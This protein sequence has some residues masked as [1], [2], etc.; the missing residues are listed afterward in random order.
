MIVQDPELDPEDL[1]EESDEEMSECDEETNQISKSNADTSGLNDPS[2]VSGHEIGSDT[3]AADSKKND[4]NL[5]AKSG[6]MSENKDGK[7]KKE[8]SNPILK[9]F[10]FN[11]KN[12]LDSSNKQKDNSDQVLDIANKDQEEE[13]TPEERLNALH[14]RLERLEATYQQEIGLI[15]TEMSALSKIITNNSSG[16]DCEPEINDNSVI[17]EQDET[18][19]AFDRQPSNSINKI[20]RHSTSRSSIASANNSKRA[21]PVSINNMNDE[22]NRSSQNVSSREN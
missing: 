6:K 12:N 2:C 21:T 13:R 18:E 10:S 3:G 17:I 22:P 14:Q 4:G 16:T 5:K 11:S 8:K 15:K 20:E 19:E 1:P 7:Q 9:F